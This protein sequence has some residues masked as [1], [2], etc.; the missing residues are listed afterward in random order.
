MTTALL[1]ISLPT[2]PCK[3]HLA[4]KLHIIGYQNGKI[5]VKLARLNRSARM[6]Q[7]AP[8]YCSLTDV[9][10]EAKLCSFWQ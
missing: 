5:D 4:R 1:T 8:S 6:S 7:S 2:A 9:S 3:L 10:C